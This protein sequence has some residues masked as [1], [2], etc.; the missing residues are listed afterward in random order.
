MRVDPGHS[1]LLP[2]GGRAMIQDQSSGGRS[3][4]IGRE[5]KTSKNKDARL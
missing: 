1:V 2:R 3:S 5:L 4:G